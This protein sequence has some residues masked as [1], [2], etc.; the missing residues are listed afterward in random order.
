MSALFRK[1]CLYAEAAPAALAAI[2]LFTLM[3]MT[4]MDVMLRSAFNEPI[5]AASEL[6]RILMAVIVF[7]SLPIISARGTHIVVDLIDPLFRG[8]A[9]RIR[10]GVIDI[11]AGLL[12]IWPTMRCFTLAE[13]A[14]DFGDVTEFLNIPQ[15]YIIYFITFFAAVTAIVLLAKGIITLFIPSLLAPPQERAETMAPAQEG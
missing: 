15:F 9:V 10:D 8:I 13:R 12:M 5:E 11:I 3:V 14:R 1:T 7:S 6:T 2:A 4:F